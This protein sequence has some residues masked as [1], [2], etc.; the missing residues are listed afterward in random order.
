M[1]NFRL[2]I[3]FAVLT[4]FLGIGLIACGGPTPKV[5]EVKDFEGKWLAIKKEAY[6]LGGGKQ[7]GFVIEFFNDKTVMLPSGKGSWEI[8]K[9]GQVKIAA[10]GMTMHGSLEKDLLTITMPDN[11]GKVIFKKQ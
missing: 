11:K 10:V 1:R 4:A 8:L 3:A 7:V 2:T 5:P 9:D 6:L